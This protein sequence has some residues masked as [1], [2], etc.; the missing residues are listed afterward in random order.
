MTFFAPSGF[1]SET[2]H[3]LVAGSCAPQK[4][5][6]G[7]FDSAAGAFESAAGAEF[8]MA[9][10]KAKPVTNTDRCIWFSLIGTK[11]IASRGS[12]LSSKM[13]APMADGLDQTSKRDW[14]KAVV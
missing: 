13:G 5:V 6:A 1:F 9:T 8:T 10:K 14:I 7:A 4:S 3:F 2:L 12:I 11:T